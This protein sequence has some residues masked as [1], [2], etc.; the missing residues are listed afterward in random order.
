M[1]QPL[2]MAPTQGIAKEPSGSGGATSFCL[3]TAWGSMFLP[4]LPLGWG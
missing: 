2:A 3:F 1:D 4:R